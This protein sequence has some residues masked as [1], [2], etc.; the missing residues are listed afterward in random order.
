M[1]YDHTKGPLWHN[2]LILLTLGAAEQD[3]IIDEVTS[4]LSTA[5]TDAH[6][7]FLTRLLEAWGQGGVEWVHYLGLFHVFSSL[8]G[9]NP[10]VGTSGVENCPDFLRRARSDIKLTNIGQ[11]LR[12]SQRLFDLYVLQH[13][14]TD[15]L[16]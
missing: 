13:T 6:P 15:C 9:K 12:I 2:K 5:K 7:V 11:I 1:G 4:D 14:C 10:G 16:R 8:F 3:L